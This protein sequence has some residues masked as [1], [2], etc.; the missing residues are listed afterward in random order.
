MNDLSTLLAGLAGAVLSLG[1]SYIPGLNGWYE[2]QSKQIKQLIM[3]ACLVV[4]TLG[5][6]AVTCWDLLSIPGLVCGEPG[7]KTLIVAFGAAMV[8]NQATYPLT[9]RA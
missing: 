2:A 7:I 3:L 1:F 6:Y 8:V 9:K 5:T 4:A